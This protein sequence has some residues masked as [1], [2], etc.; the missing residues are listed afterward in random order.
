M[1]ADS[2]GWIAVWVFVVS[3]GVIAVELAVG[4]LWGLR[5]ARNGRA[6]AAALQSER[7]L[8]EADMARL[9]AAMDETRELWRPY[10]RVLH[11]LRHP[12]IVAL[13]GYY[14]RPRRR[15]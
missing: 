7:A 12:L 11:W 6:V 3:S 13:I 2:A 10:R 4:G 1:T 14:R 5:L 9:R 15:R 8:V